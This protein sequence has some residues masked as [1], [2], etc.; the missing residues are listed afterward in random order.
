[1]TA[2]I[3]TSVPFDVLSYR[4]WVLSRKVAESY[5]VRNVFLQVMLFPLLTISDKIVEPVMLHILSHQPV[6]WG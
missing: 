1:V 3:G 4:P 2:A 5:R 6:A